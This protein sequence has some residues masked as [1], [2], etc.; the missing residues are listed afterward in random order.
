[1]LMD[2]FKSAEAAGAAVVVSA[3]A[4]PAVVV[5]ASDCAVVGAAVDS[6]VLLPHPARVPIVKTAIPASASV[7]TMFF[8]IIVLLKKRG[9]KDPLLQI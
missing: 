2:P 3:E 4:V 8:F 7:F 5:S 6:V 1:M 9:G